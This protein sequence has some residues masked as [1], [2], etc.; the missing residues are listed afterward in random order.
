VLL[1]TDP[2]AGASPLA[3]PC[4]AA[5]L[6]RYPAAAAAAPAGTLAEDLARLVGAAHL[7]ICYIYYIIYYDGI[8]RNSWG[9]LAEVLARLVAP[10]CRCYYTL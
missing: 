1:V 3:N 7:V 2:P 9:A 6:R 8:I 5:V 10:D 4:A